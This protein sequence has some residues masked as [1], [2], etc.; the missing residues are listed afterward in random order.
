M[1]AAKKMLEGVVK[2]RHAFRAPFWWQAQHLVN[3]DLD[4]VL[5]ASKIAFVKLSSCLILDMMLISWYS[6][7]DASETLEEFAVMSVIS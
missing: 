2:M 1:D 6:T 4:D 7:S 5:K 3:L